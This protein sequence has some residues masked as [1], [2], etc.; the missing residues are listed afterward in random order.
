M[1]LASSVYPNLLANVLRIIVSLVSL[2][3][4]FSN[5]LMPMLAYDM[6]HINLDTLYFMKICFHHSV[7]FRQGKYAGAKWLG[8]L[9]LRLS[10]NQISTSSNFCYISKS[11]MQHHQKLDPKLDLA[12]FLV[13]GYWKY[14]FGDSS[15]QYICSVSQS[16][17]STIEYGVLSW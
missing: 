15:T 13:Y 6:L 8:F 2:F 11:M 16:A 5:T 14:M 1:L 7:G 12:W 4:S 17:L 10:I 9:V 3:L